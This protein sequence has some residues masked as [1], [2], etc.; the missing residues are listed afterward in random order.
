M[1][2]AR[3]PDHRGFGRLG[4]VDL[5]QGSPIS[6]PTSHRCRANMAHTRQSMPDPGLGF[7][8][9]VLKRSTVFPLR[10]GPARRSGNPSTLNPSTLNSLGI[11][12]ES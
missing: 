9:K 3:P 7:Q 4:Q 10:A 6:N 11:N 5:Y 8:I 1:T 12:F 2:F